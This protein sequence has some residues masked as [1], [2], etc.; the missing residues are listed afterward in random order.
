M[1]RI[2]AFLACF[3]ITVLFSMPLA[4]DQDSSDS[5]PLTR[6][7]TAEIEI[8]ATISDINYET[9]EVDITDASGKV[10]S[11]TV[12][13]RVKRFS[14]L[15]VGDRVTVDI[16]LSALAEVREPTAEELAN[17]GAVTRGVVR[18]PDSRALSG[19]MIEA[20]TS[21]VTVVAL[22][23]ITETITVL[24]ENGELVD[25]S[26][27]SIDNLK[28]LRLGDTIV[29]TYSEAIAVAVEQMA[30]VAAE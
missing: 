3:L 7:E 1:N 20:V 26:A 10:R 22:N 21:V 30:P 2:P 13:P 29:V 23:L 19:S 14:E 11:I 8:H 25:V 24:A 4:A 5:E 12:D 6:E 15:K 17:P 27:Q 9:R 28:K 18:S 16:V